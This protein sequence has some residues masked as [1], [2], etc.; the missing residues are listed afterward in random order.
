MPTLRCLL[1]SGVVAAAALFFLTHTSSAQAT[2]VAVTGGTPTGLF[3][4]Y[5]PNAITALQTG[6]NAVSGSLGPNQTITRFRVN[7]NITA[8]GFLMDP[9]TVVTQF[10]QGGQGGALGAGGNNG[11]GGGGGY[12]SYGG[13]SGVAGGAATGIGLFST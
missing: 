9:L 5:D 6:F 10:G 8:S 13:A 7:T 4:Q 1:K 12:Q 11:F 2:P 3:S